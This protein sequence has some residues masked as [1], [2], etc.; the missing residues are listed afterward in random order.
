MSENKAELG[1]FEK[2]LTLWVIVSMFAG[3]LLGR[4]FPGLGLWIETL[5]IGDVS[6]PMGVCLFLLMYP[7]MASIE[8]KEIVKAAKS[9]R[10]TV[11]TLIG[12]WVVAPALMALLARL[13]LAGYAEYAA[14]VIL[15]GIAPCTGMVLFWILLAQGDVAKGVVITAI[16]ALSTLLLYTPLAAFYLGVGGVPVPVAPIAES[17]ILFVGL[18]LALGQIS[19]KTLMEKKGGEWFNNR[20]RPLIGR[21][22]ALALLATIIILFSMKG[23]AIADQPLL[24]GLISMPLLTHFFIMATLFYA[25]PWLL[26]FNYRDSV[27]IAFISSGT[28]FEVAIATATVVFGAGSEAALATVVGPLWEVPSMLLFV[29]L[30][31]RGRRYFSEVD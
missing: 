20:F 13:F 17:V 14:G 12:N 30:A 10:P 19:R 4:F 16:N 15:L 24:V 11:L 2:Y 22:A 5:Q 23:E 1:G 8:F 18:P 7:T 27:T 9:P 3:F 25:I 31:L 6:I 29:K 21:L 28:Q 26:G